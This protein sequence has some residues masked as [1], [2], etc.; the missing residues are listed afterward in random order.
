MNPATVAS[1]P[2]AVEQRLIRVERGVRLA[3][4]TVLLLSSAPNIALGLSIK[5]YTETFSTLLK[6][7]SISPLAQMVLAHPIYLV[8]LAFLWPVAGT[9]ITVRARDPFRAMS[10]SCIYLVL[11]SGQF[12]LTWFALLSP[13]QSALAYL[14]SQ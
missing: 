5:S 3:A 8:V 14:T 4:V 2:N 10:A 1:S 7:A 13:L 9:L 11:V 12:A 6:G